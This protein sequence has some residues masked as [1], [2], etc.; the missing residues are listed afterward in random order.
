MGGN[1]QNYDGVVLTCP[2][3]MEYLSYGIDTGQRAIKQRPQLL[4]Q[5]VQIGRHAVHEFLEI[6]DLEGLDI[7]LGQELIIDIRYVLAGQLPLIEGL[8]R[9]M[10]GLAALSGHARI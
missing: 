5:C 10:P 6:G 9:M 4:I 3:S 7:L 1:R 2:V 8:H